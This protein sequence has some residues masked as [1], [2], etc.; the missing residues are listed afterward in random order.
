MMHRHEL[1]AIIREK[2]EAWAQ[3]AAADRRCL[4]YQ[5]SRATAEG[6]PELP[7]G[8]TERRNELRERYQDVRQRYL[9]ITLGRRN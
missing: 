6:Y 8:W 4:A 7:E 9:R 5:R 1:A 2:N 3:L